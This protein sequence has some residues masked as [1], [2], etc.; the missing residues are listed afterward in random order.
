MKFR[1]TIGLVHCLLG[2]VEKS[3]GKELN[4]EYILHA[5]NSLISTKTGEDEEQ[6]INI[7]PKHLETKLYI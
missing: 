6:N 1:D 7:K 3:N 2:M 4:S 5:P